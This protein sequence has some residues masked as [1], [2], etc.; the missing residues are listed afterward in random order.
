MLI[1]KHTY[2]RWFIGK[3]VRAAR[4]AVTIGNRSFVVS[5]TARIFYQQHN[6]VTLCRRVSRYS[7][8]AVILTCV[9]AAYAT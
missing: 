6:V 4:E 8:L 9:C 3:A 7:N 1:H 5:D 2:L